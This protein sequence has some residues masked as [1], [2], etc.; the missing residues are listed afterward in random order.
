MPLQV[1]NSVNNSRRTIIILSDHFHESHWANWEFRVAHA[2][3]FAEGR[4][5][6]IVIIKGNINMN[7]LNPDLQQFLKINTSLKSDDP[8]FWSKLKYAMPHMEKCESL[9]TI[10]LAVMEEQ[11]QE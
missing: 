5:R 8:L 9:E 3:S 1:I 6:V 10:P 4:S 7:N 11:S 2:N